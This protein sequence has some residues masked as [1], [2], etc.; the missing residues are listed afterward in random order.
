MAIGDRLATVG[1]TID[2][3]STPSTGRWLWYHGLAFY[4]AMQ[5]ATAGLHALARSWRRDTRGKRHAAGRRYLRGDTRWSDALKRPIFQPPNWL[6]PVAWTV[7]NVCQIWG[8]LHVIK[9]PRETRGR[10]AYL[11]LQ[12]ATWADYAVFSAG[13]FGLRSTINSVV[14]TGLYLILTLASGFVALFRLRDW[15]VAVSLLTTTVW[16]CVAL[17]SAI[18]QARWNRD[19][20]YGVGPFAKPDR[21]LLKR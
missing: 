3:G 1:H 13:Y 16:L 7:N 20:F 19:E 5:L 10:T 21:A 12:A 9:K 17:P 6:F 14:L 11:A 15:K 18:A 2:A 8:E 4:V